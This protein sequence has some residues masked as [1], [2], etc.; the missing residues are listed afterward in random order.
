[1]TGRQSYLDVL[2][3]VSVFFV[4]VVH[5]SAINFSK[6]DVFSSDWMACNIYD[7]IAHFAAP[8]LFMVSGAIFLNPDKTVTI[9]RLFKRNIPHVIIAFAFWSALYSLVSSYLQY[10]TISGESIHSFFAGFVEGPY[11]LWFCYAIV[12]CYIAT[13][14]LRQI[15]RDEIIEKY[16]LKVLLL[17]VFIVNALKLI[18]TFRF[19]FKTIYSQ[20]GIVLGGYIVYFIL[21]HYLNDRKT[22]RNHIR[23]AWGG[24]LPFWG[25]YPY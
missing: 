5:V 10:R 21:G 8:V 7:S 6:I 25:F 3:T 9:Q 22:E 11:H 23:F 19:V 17:A 13:P 14:I 24:V 4:V 1:M 15:L 16:M 18:P 20:G 12:F 2:K